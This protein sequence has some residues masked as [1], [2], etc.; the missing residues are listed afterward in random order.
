[1]S[2]NMI[3]RISGNKYLITDRYGLGGGNWLMSFKL[4]SN[5]NLEVKQESRFT[6][7][8]ICTYEIHNGDIHIFLENSRA[9][10]LMVTKDYKLWV[11]G[12]GGAMDF[13]MTLID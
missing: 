7:V 2:S 11:A 10:D 1:M 4:L 13:P 8:F 3:D 6:T 5:D 12:H 9:Y